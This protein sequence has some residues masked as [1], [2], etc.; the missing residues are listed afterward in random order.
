MIVEVVAV[1]T[2]LLL[3][4]VV[5]TNAA[6]IGSALAERGF[7]CHYQQVVGD[8]LERVARSVRLGMERADAVVITGGIGPT[9]DDLTREAVCA[10]TG[11][12]LVYSE[13]QAARLRDWWARRGGTMP[14]S[15]L[16]QAYHPEGAELLENPKG[17]APGLV[18]DHPD[19]LI[20]CIPGVPEEMEAMLHEE[21]LPR[22]AEAADGE[23]AIVSRLVRTWGRP[24][25]DVAEIL[26]DL[27]QGTNPS[28]AFLASSSE[29]KV[30]ITAKAATPEAARRIIEPVETEV[31]S[32][33]G[34]SVFGFDEETIEEVVLAL[35][36]ER[37]YTI[38]TAESMTGGLVAA[39]LTA[40]PGA[41]AVVKGGLVAY[42]REVKQ[43]LLGLAP[44]AGL[45]GP[46]TAEAMARGARDLLR[47]DVAVAITGSAGPEPLERPPGTVVVA[48]S[49]PEAT[50]A[51]QIRFSGDRERIRAYGSTAALHLTR[52]ALR[53]TWWSA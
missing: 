33:L 39:R 3:G 51:R 27:F 36:S 43:R 29:I 20:F 26:D 2:E 16:R 41:S 11:L 19:S 21:V 24:E 13:D 12:G 38:G 10:A 44:E 17:T 52:L 45:V 42:Q 6:L 46:D 53:G 18:V 28:I 31:V 35:L 4:Q 15:N 7:D 30:R 23:E 37:G 49:T 25:S 1:G 5:N 9:P 34:E 50:R 32:R 47:V 40:V 48:V 14:Q 22:L 8:N